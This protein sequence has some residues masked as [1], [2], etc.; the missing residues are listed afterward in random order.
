VAG[1]VGYRAPGRRPGE[2][3]LRL[4]FYFGKHRRHVLLPRASLPEADRGTLPFSFPPL[5][6]PHEFV[7]GPDV[8][9]VEVVSPGAGATVV[10]SNAAAAAVHVMPP[11]AP[12]PGPP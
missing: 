6:D 12:R 3:S 10:E 9:F 8:V 4:T 2:S 1:S 5:G 7:P 11:E